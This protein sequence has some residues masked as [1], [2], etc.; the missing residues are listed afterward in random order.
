VQYL[1]AIVIVPP[2]YEEQIARW[3]EARRQRLASPDGWLTLV[4]RIALDEGDNPLP[5]GTLTLRAGEAR[6]R[7]REGLEVTCE[8]AAVRERVLRSDADGTADVLTCGGRTHELLRRGDLF[9]VR[10]KDPQA[11]ARLRFTGVDSFPVDP[12]WRIVARFERYEPPHETFHVYEIGVR[13]ARQVPGRASFIVGGRALA[14]EP[15]LE[16]PSNRLFFVFSDETNRT[17]TYPAGRFLYADL[18]TADEVVLDFN[19]AFN[20]PCAFTEFAVC[21]VTPAANRLPIAIPAGE[22]RYEPLSG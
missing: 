18:P 3:R 22:R 9:F 7:A 8:G 15:V 2:S 4:D 1:S 19:V 6:F 12:A 11:P 21:P 17:E 20:P 13:E 14:L 16:Q 10:V 5:I